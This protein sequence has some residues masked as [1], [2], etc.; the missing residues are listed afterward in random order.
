MLNQDYDYEDGDA[1]YLNDSRK[2]R[3][4]KQSR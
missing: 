4:S 3:I 2:E 1:L